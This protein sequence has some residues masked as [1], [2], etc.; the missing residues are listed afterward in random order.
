MVEKND[1]LMTVESAIRLAAE[2]HQGQRDKAGMPYITHPIAV[3]AYLAA[4]MEPNHETEKYLMCA[5]LH[6][7]LEDTRCTESDLKIYGA[8][9]ELR[10]AVIAITK[11]KDETYWNYIHRVRE[12]KIARF[13]KIADLHHNMDLSRFKGKEIT[14]A[15]HD[16]VDKYKEALI[17]LSDKGW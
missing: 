3:I 14:A 12:N 6:D 10:E 13:V 9:R 5:A 1:S 16:R 7:V 4:R 11:I 8:N 17:M 15:D 2:Y